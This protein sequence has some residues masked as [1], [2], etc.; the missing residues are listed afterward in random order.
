MK[1]LCCP[2]CGSKRIQATTETDVRTT[3][4][5]YSVGQGCLGYLLLGPLGLLCGSCGSGQKT[6]TTST[7]YWVCPNCGNKFQSPQDIRSEAQ[8]KK[9]ASVALII[10]GIV[11]AIGTYFVMSS[12]PDA[13]SDVAPLFILFSAFIFLIFWIASAV[14]KSQAKSLEES[15][16]SLE[17]SMLDFQ[18]NVKKRINSQ[19]NAVDTAGKWICSCGMENL[20]CSNYCGNCGRAHNLPKR[21]VEDNEWQCPNCGKIHQNYVGTCGCGTRKN[22]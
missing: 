3:G 6:T 13:P 12:I 5:N 7:T 10:I 2:K 1:E 9:S 19:E 18:S 21:S 17:L 8:N 15:A 11:F 4:K 22:G 14:A 20:I 16:E